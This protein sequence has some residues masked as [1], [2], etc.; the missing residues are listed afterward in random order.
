MLTNPSWVKRLNLEL[1]LAS[2]GQ[3]FFPSPLR[4]GKSDWC[5]TLQVCLNT[6]R[7]LLC[8][9]SK[10]KNIK[11]QKLHLLFSKRGRMGFL[12]RLQ[13]PDTGLQFLSWQGQVWAQFTPNWP[14]SQ[15]RLQLKEHIKKKNSDEKNQY[16]HCVHSNRSFQWKWNK[17]A[18]GIKGNYVDIG[19]ARTGK[20]N[21]AFAM[22]ETRTD[23]LI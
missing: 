12:H 19:N 22:N 14:N 21:L 5:W 10:L 11:L 18:W 8:L 23:F 15:V 1:T 3:L 7:V 4:N 20:R 13:A 6:L 2:T 17:A 9:H 16:K